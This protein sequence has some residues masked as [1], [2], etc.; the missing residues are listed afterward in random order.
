MENDNNLEKEQFK[1][2]ARLHN[3]AK[4]ID[5]RLPD[6]FGFCLL[7]FPFGEQK[8][9]EIMYVSNANRED[10][11]K[12]MKEWIDRTENNFANDAKKF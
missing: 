5:D 9:G 1:V 11:V 8:N 4:N 6:G 12:A 2:K 7:T 10:I 3:I